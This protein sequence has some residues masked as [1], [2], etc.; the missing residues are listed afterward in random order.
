MESVANIQNN[1][2]KKLAGYVNALRPIIYINH[3]DFQAVDCLI[4]AINDKAKIKEYNEA[5]GEV[6]FETKA[7]KQ[8]YDLNSFLLAFDDNE[9]KEIFLVLKDV[10]HKLRNPEICARLR[11]IAE[12]TIYKEGMNVTV[13][14]VC[15]EL[16]LPPE[17]EKIVTIFDIPYPGDSQIKAIINDYTENFNIPIADNTRERLTVSFRGL[18]DFEIRQILNLAYQESGLIDHDS[19]KLVLEEKKQVIKKSDILELVQDDSDFDDIGG[20]EG[21]KDYL[22]KKEKVFKNIGEANKFGLDL[23]KGILIVGYPGCG[24]TLSAKATARLFDVPLLRLDIGKIMGMYVGESE[25][26]L[27]RAIKTAEAV[28]PCVLWIDEIEKAFAGIN[29]Q[30]GASDII[31]RLF[32][33]FLTWLQEKKGAVYVVATSNNIEKLPPEFLRRGRFDE[34]FL[35]KLPNKTERKKIFENHLRKRGQLSGEIDI[36]SLLEKSPDGGKTCKGTEGF[37]GADIESVV[38]EAIEMAFFANGTL[39]TDILQECI[40][41][42]ISLSDTMKDEIEEL[43]KRYEKHNFKDANK[44]PEITKKRKKNEAVLSSK[45]SGNKGYGVGTISPGSGG[46]AG[47]GVENIIGS[48]IG[49]HPIFKY[50]TNDIG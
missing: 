45:S 41:N 6:D 48:L 7:R 5:D 20:L 43:K 32:G 40:N 31:T 34:L 38:K 4:R 44:E 21:L 30:S 36:Y 29:G 10:H 24:K 15:S 49:G 19:A 18:S 9:E 13:F 14:L 25:R 8:K 33:T 17:L 12:K 3:F 39:S 42:T 1:A 27:V 23:P 47:Y 26:N 16:V 35:V 22:L 2:V 37:S 28:A 50:L 11:S 46:D